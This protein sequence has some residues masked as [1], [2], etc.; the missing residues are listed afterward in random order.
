M[1]ATP[2]CELWRGGGSSRRKHRVPRSSDRPSC[3][4]CRAAPGAG[5]RGA[6][7]VDI[8]IG[9]RDL[10][11]AV[12]RPGGPGGQPVNTTDSGV[13]IPHLPPGTVVQQQDE[14][15]KHKNK[16]KALRVLRARL[17]DM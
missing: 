10:R 17:Y 16:P 13:R 9:E 6:E 14:K 3:G 2:R 1:R 5:V 4:C 8:K 7:E 12:S 11:F 15:S